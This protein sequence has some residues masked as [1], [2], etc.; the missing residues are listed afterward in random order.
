MDIPSEVN[1]GM[2][3]LDP[4]TQWIDLSSW[5]WFQILK[6][7]E[8]EFWSSLISLDYP[9]TSLFRIQPLDFWVP[10]G[11][12]WWVQRT[13]S[14]SLRIPQPQISFGKYLVPSLSLIRTRLFPN[15]EWV[16]SGNERWIV[17]R[18]SSQELE[19]ENVKVPRESLRFI[20]NFSLSQIHS[21]YWYPEK[22]AY[23][24]QFVYWPQF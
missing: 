14:H 15:F 23:Y 2:W 1:I 3:N 20:P 19:K 12:R 8:F 13:Q 22:C 6:E 18:E 4:E 9:E 7:W 17:T 16:K 10:E 5:E 11:T 24:D 21:I